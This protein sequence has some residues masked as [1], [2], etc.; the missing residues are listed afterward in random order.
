M[1]VGH[2]RGRPNGERA[3]EKI[4]RQREARMLRF[5][6]SH[7]NVEIEPQDLGK[8]TST[9]QAAVRLLPWAW[10]LEVALVP[11]QPFAT[12]GRSRSQ[13]PSF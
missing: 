3:G 12:R 11:L 7:G 8:V 4:R 9:F 13:C 1:E 6:E 2:A 10:R 5:V